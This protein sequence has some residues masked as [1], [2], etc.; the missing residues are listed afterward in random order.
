MLVKSPL[1][2]V[3]GCQ[4]VPEASSFAMRRVAHMTGKDWPNGAPID[5]KGEG[6][7][8][9]DAHLAGISQNLKLGVR[10]QSL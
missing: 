10:T 5:V 3:G 9:E 7:S 6:L 2:L 4:T 8:A 1:A